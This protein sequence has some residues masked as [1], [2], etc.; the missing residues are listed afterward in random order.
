VPSGP[1]L[2]S[3][4]AVQQATGRR[5]TLATLPIA[6]VRR[7]AFVP[8]VRAAAALTRPTL[9]EPPMRRLRL[10]TPAI[11]VATAVAV[12]P[13]TSSAAARPCPGAYLAPSAAH[14]AQVRAATVC[15]LN[16]QR[17]LHGLPRLR[18]QRSLSHAAGNYARL[19][20]AQRFFAHVSPSGSTPAQRIKHTNYLRGTRVWALGENI[21]WGS[22]AAAT[23]ARIVS[24]WMHSP[25]H[26]R[27]ILDPAYR[28]MGLGIAV[29]APNGGSGATYVNEFGRRG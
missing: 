14:A 5:L 18:T 27:N 4:T 19:M 22:G 3:R 24:A 9:P 26:R 7:G 13:A 23:P 16:R 29:G 8:L 12:A 17:V 1:R 21:A 25:G 15:L 11:A 28:D 10:L 6:G 20:V 2:A